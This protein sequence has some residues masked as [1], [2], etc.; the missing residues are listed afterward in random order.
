MAPKGSKQARLQESVLESTEWKRLFFETKRYDDCHQLL[1]DAL[2]GGPAATYVQAILQFRHEKRKRRT[3][4]EVAIAMS[5]ACAPHWFA[6]FESALWLLYSTERSF[7]KEGPLEDTVELSQCSKAQRR[8]L[9]ASGWVRLRPHGLHKRAE[10]Y[11]RQAVAACTLA[12]FMFWVDNYN[13]FRYSRNPNEDRDMCINATVTS[14][15]PLPG[16][17]RTFWTGWATAEAVVVAVMPVARALVQQSKLLCDRFRALVQKNLAYEHVRIPLDI[18]RYQVSTMPWQP[19]GLVNADLKYTE[20]LNSPCVSHPVWKNS[21]PFR[22]VILKNVASDC[23]DLEILT[24]FV[25]Y[26]SFP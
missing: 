2:S 13:K 1:R 11:R 24:A 26:G 12:A 21:T 4:Q 16:V 9:H 20:G 7:W 19:F 23:H 17:D 14:V 6:R 8:L 25:Q 18:R 10:E 22:R 15:L 3:L 5:N